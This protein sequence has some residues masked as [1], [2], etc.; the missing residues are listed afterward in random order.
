VPNHHDGSGATRPR[1]TSTV[2][3]SHE[4]HDLARAAVRLVRRK[5]GRP[6]SLTQF[7]REALAAQ[8][9][10]IAD[11]YNDGRAIRPD[12]EPLERGRAV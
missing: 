8:L 4:L 12:E 1:A 6:Y 5:T 2:N 11:T 10:I 3:V 9:K 7:V